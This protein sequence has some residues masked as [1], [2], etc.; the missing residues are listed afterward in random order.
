MIFGIILLFVISAGPLSEGLAQNP[1]SYRS[2]DRLAAEGYEKGYQDFSIQERNEIFGRLTSAER[3]LLLTFES[4][5]PEERADFFDRLSEHEKQMVFKYVDHAQK[6]NIFKM[7]SDTGKIRL[8]ASLD[9]EEKIVFFRYL[10]QNDRR[11]IFGR[12]NDTDKKLIFESLGDAGQQEYLLTFPGLSLIVEKKERPDL[13]LEEPLKPVEE[14]PPPSRIEKILSG[15]FPTDIARE[16][17]QYGYDFFSKDIYTTAYEDRPGMTSEPREAFYPI[18]SI[19]V[20]PDY[21]IGPEDQFTIHLWGKVEKEYYVTVTRDGTIIVPRLGSLSVG[22]LTFGELKRLLYNKFKE[23]YPGFEMS[24]TMGRLRTITVFIVGEAEKPGTYAVNSL[25]TIISAL[26]AANGPSK[27][28]SLRNIKVF[29]N[30]NVAGILDLYE[31]FI[32]GNK[33][34]DIRLQTGD[35]IFIPVIGPVVGVAGNVRRPAIYEL[36]GGETVGAVIGMAGNVLP[37]GHLQNIVVERIVDHQRRV[38]KSFNMDSD[39]DRINANLSISL[40][41]GD[42]IKIYPVYKEL[43]EVVFL[44]GHVKYPREFELKFGMRLSDLISAYDDLLPEPYLPRAEIVRL[45]PPD[46]HAEIV[47]FN[48]GALLEGDKAQNLLLQDLDRVKIYGMTDKE[49]IPEVT[50]SGAVRSPGT[51]RL[52]KGMKIKDLIFQAANLTNRAFLERASLSRV[53]AGEAGTE[54]LKITFSPNKAIAGLP[55]DNLFLQPDDNVYIREIP[56]YGRALERKVYIEGDFLFPGEYAYSEGERLSSVIE[57]AGGLTEQAY[58]AGAVFQRESVKLIQ[59]ERLDEYVNK[60]EEDIYTL[61]A[62]AGSTALDANEA[63]IVAQT[64]SSK[65]QLVEKMKASETTGRMVINLDK[66]LAAPSSTDNF[67]LKPGDRLI[68]NKEPDFV[69]VLGEVF[70]PTALFAEKSKTVGYYLSRVGGVTENAQT[71]QMYLVRANGTVISK[72]QE[73]YFGLASWDTEDHRWTI[74]GFDSVN[75]NAGDSIIVP[76]K[77]EKYP[78]LKATKDITT[79]LY[80]IAVTAGVAIAA[81]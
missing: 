29:R 43:R 58:P 2:S 38:I 65:K 47:D 44:E 70:N 28:G 39:Y 81:F 63:A 78:W 1:E 76:K 42:V 34:N 4:L 18:T 11:L 46:L 74:G 45:M 19:P 72:T 31:F 56:Q 9:T 60:L 5:K 68:V 15:E 66:L 55:E 13:R 22:G 73:G 53:V 52:L 35:T 8:F 61:S 24:I 23:Y 32:R 40:M 6:A 25:S 51:Y 20:G 30:G 80:Q 64:L 59:Q 77:V 48:L 17:R 14:E 75:I 54:T 36:K 79:V 57:R 62:Q 3:E 71:N 50:I 33:G 41:D 37:T 12:L 16:L 7:L 67:K 21:I 69:N 26:Y 27:N 49:E 10:E